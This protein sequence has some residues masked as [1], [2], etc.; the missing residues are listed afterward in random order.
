MIGERIIELVAYMFSL[1]ASN[2][3]KRFGVEDVESL[4]VMGLIRDLR[5]S[6]W[7]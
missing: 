6:H 5:V 7:L 1:L 2:G 3:R 4:A